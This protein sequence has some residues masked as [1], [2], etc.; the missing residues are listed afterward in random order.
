MIAERLVQIAQT[1]LNALLTLHFFQVLFINKPRTE[2]ETKFIV[3]RRG[4]KDGEDLPGADIAHVHD[5][6]SHLRPDGRI[7]GGLH[8]LGRKALLTGQAGR[9]TTGDQ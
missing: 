6:I 8:I 1:V 2:S 5:G 4:R 7:F 3:I 9:R